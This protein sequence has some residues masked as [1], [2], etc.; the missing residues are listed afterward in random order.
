MATRF[1]ETKIRYFSQCVIYAYT[2][3]AI[4]LFYY[5]FF[6]SFTCLEVS[7]YLSCIF[8]ASGVND[9]RALF[10]TAYLMAEMWTGKERVSMEQVEF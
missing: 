6:I 4:G 5:V 8:A 2:I 3:K 9:F 10:L 1:F 7:R